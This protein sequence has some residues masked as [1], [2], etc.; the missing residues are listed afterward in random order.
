MA[1]KAAKGKKSTQRKLTAILCADVQGYFRP[2][3]DDEAATFKILGEYR[4]VFYSYMRQCLRWLHG[5]G[6][7]QCSQYLAVAL[8]LIAALPL[9]AAGCR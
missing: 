5:G 1:T 2:M 7:R 8:L 9:P 6:G 3:G 4:E